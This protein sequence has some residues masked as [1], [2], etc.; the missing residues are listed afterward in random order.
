MQEVSDKSDLYRSLDECANA[1]LG[2]LVLNYA[3][4]IDDAK[5]YVRRMLLAK[6]AEYKVRGRGRPLGAK[7]KVPIESLDPPSQARRRRRERAE[8]R[9]IA[10]IFDKFIP[11]G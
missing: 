2:A 1:L 9:A 8:V 7:S 11:K 4:Y 6:A 10:G 5:D 3:W